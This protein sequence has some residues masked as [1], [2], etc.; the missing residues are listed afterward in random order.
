MQIN[1]CSRV[2]KMNDA[3]IPEILEGLER[4]GKKYM[5]RLE[6]YHTELAR[7][8]ETREPTQEERR[9]FKR[10]GQVLRTVRAL[11]F[12]ITEEESKPKIRLVP[13]K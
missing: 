10:I 8:R 1:Q 11:S 4:G 2:V 9:W 12:D 5:A 6:K 13:K 7:I 3:R